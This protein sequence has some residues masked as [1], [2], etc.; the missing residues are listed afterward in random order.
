MNGRLEQEQLVQRRIER[1]LKKLPA[2]VRDW[3]YSLCASDISITS[4]DMYINKIKLFLQFC[5]A[6]V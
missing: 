2:Y 5:S 6:D 3:Y 1:K 4:C